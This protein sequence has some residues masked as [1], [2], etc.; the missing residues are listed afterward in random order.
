MQLQK[1]LPKAQAKTYH[2]RVPGSKYTFADGFSI[3]FD[4]GR[5]RFN[6]EDFAGDQFWCQTMNNQPPHAFN[7]MDKADVYFKELEDLIKAPNPLIF[8]QGQN[9]DVKLPDELNPAKNARSEA[10]IH[11][12]DAK[13]RAGGIS[14]RETGDANLGPTTSDVNSSTVDREL[15]QRVLAPATGSKADEIRAAAQAR[16]QTQN[17]STPNNM[18]N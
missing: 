3:T 16:A 2:S 1:D 10:E 4:F 11:E 6:P 13:L 15:Q 18:S 7:G 12:M 17:A 8:V 14:G 5:Y 9:P